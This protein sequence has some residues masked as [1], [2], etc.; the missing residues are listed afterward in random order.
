[1]CGILLAVGA[2]FRADFDAALATLKSRGP[3]ARETLVHGDALLGHARLVLTAPGACLKWRVG[4]GS[5]CV[6]GNP[7]RG[8]VT[9]SQWWT[10]KDQLVADV[11]LGAFLSG[12]IDSSLVVHYMAQAGARS[13]KTFS[14]RFAEAGFD[15]KPA[16]ARRG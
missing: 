7:L 12:G 6:P 5:L 8:Q 10:V 15:E 13:L 2:T 14:V 16:C 4:A 11:P 3:D 1:M 9:V